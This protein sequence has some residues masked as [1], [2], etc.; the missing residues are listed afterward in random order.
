MRPFCGVDVTNVR[1]EK[2]WE[3]YI[4]GGW[5]IWERK[6]TVLNNSTSHKCQGVKWSKEI[7]LG[8]KLNPN[9]DFEW[10]IA[11]PNLPVTEK[12]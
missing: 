6:M 4:P 11:I 2:E 1:N 12:Y 7:A 8:D 9:K 3:K 5:E 10:E